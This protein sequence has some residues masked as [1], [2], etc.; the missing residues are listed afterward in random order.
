M[1]RYKRLAVLIIR[2]VENDK[3]APRPCCETLRWS[4]DDR[5]CELQVTKTL[6]SAGFQ[7]RFSIGENASVGSEVLRF[8]DIRCII[9]NVTTIQSMA[10]TT[11]VLAKVLDTLYGKRSISENK[12]RVS[13]TADNSHAAEEA[14]VATEFMEASEEALVPYDAPSDLL[15]RPPKNPYW[16]LQKAR[17]LIKD[18]VRPQEEAAFRRHRAQLEANVSF[19]DSDGMKGAYEKALVLAKSEVKIPEDMVDVCSA[20]ESVDQSVAFITDWYEKNKNWER[21]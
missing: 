5:K 8:S 4:C 17:R 16:R 2:T 1:N 11:E 14:G 12:S 9:K 20:L 19:T 3:F 15:K 13:E 21:S 6:E 18:M 7:A 10:R